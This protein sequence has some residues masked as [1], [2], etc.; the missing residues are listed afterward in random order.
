MRESTRSGQRPR[1]A[2]GTEFE[3]RVACLRFH[4]GCFV[5]RAID[6]WPTGLEGD[7][8]AELDCLVVTFDPRLR[9]VLEVVE[10][11][12]GARG[13]GEIDRLLWLRGV[14]RLARAQEV[15]FA[16]LQVAPRTRTF[17]RQLDVDVLDE[18]AITTLERDLGIAT[19]E[20]VGFHDPHF[21]ERIV[22]P[23]R[24]A[25]SSVRELQGVG[26]YLFGSF[27]F[28]DDFTR[29]KQ[30]RRAIQ[31]LIRHEG[32]LNP[33]PLQLGLGEATTL[34]MLTIVSI[35]GWQHQLA[36]TE[37]RE[38]VTRELAIGI[39]DGRS[40]RAL[41][42][43]VDDFH[44]ESIEALHAAYQQAGV[45]RLPFPTPSLE[46]EALAPPEWVDAF[47]NLVT[48][49]A[50][51]PRLATDLV[52]WTDLWAA[53][54]LGAVVPSETLR[55]LFGGQ[56]AQLH[57]SFTLLLTFLTRIWDVPADYLALA[58]PRDS[59]HDDR[60]ELLS[61]PA[62]PAEPTTQPD[63]PPTASEGEQPTETVAPSPDA[64]TLS[65]R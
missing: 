45:G 48:R 60:A 27:W 17:A 6:V 10:C 61:P 43:R 65:E 29:V 53:Q 47:I 64:P 51:Q 25:L 20:W 23:A 22:K 62:T 49:F 21:G 2:P 16:K 41:L 4:Q 12:T 59:G 8:L 3:Y 37:F 58:R 54:L 36:P 32:L 26:K 24:A 28:T 13:Q 11:K 9:R 44:R 15:T 57:D 55:A 46:V 40:L 18:A 31:L 30:L 19:G 5:R 1:I 14:E 56:E 42:R 38:L 63:H 35:A 39:G 34:L 52:R 7:K 33:A 50:Q